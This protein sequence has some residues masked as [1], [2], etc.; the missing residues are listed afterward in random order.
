[1]QLTVTVCP[2][3]DVFQVR[4]LYT[5]VLSRGKLVE[6]L[7]LFFLDLSTLSRACL[8]VPRRVFSRHDIDQEA[9][10]R[11][12]ANKSAVFLTETTMQ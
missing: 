2:L 6:A 9:V 3:A 12:E 8:L 11:V 1:M 7:V 10:H 5:L 4:C